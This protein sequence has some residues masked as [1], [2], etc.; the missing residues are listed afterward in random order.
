MNKMLTMIIA[1]LIPALSFGQ[2]IDGFNEVP[3]TGY[4][5]YEISASADSTLSFVNT[6]YVTD[7]LDEGSHALQLDYSAHNIESWGGYAKV[8][9]LHP[10]IATGGTYDWSGYDSISVRYYNS[11]AQSDEGTVHIRINLSDYAGITD[12]SYTGL[13][14]YYYS[15]HYVLDNEPGW[16]TITMPLVRNDSWDGGGF[17][18]TG[19]AGD[20]DD[21]EL[22]VHAIGGFHFEFSIGGSGEGNHTTGTIVLDNFKLTGYQGTN[23]VIF[24]GINTPPAWGNPFSWGGA[25]MYVT[26]GG[27]YDEGT[28]A[29][30]YIQEEVWSG[31]GFNMTPAVDFSSGGEW[32]SDSISFHMHSEESAPTLRLQF[33]DGTDKVGLNFDPEADGGWHHYQ[34]ALADFTYW[35]G[36]TTFDT[37]AVT[38]FQVMGEGNGASGRT[39]HFDNVWTGHPDFDVIAP[40]APE[41]IG[42]V[43]ANYYNLVTWSDVSG[44]SDELYHVYAS[45][46]PITDLGGAVELVASNVLEGSQA[47]V[48]YLYSPLEDAT[49]SYYYA[50]ICVDPAGN[51]SELGVSSSSIT[52][53][54]QGIPTISLDVPENFSADGDLSEWQDVMPFVI[55]P[56]TGHVATGNVDSDGD[57][58]GTVYLAVDDDYLYFA[59]DVVDDSYSY[60]E[61][62]WWNQD[63]LQ[64]FIGLYDWRGPK[65]TTINRGEEPDY[66]LYANEVGLHLDISNG[67]MLAAP[68]SDDYYF[69]GFDPDYAT[70]GRI[71]LDSIAAAN[72]DTRFHPV[73]GMRIPLDIYFHDNDNG[74]WEGNIGF[75]HLATDQQWNNPSEWAYTWI[76]DQSTVAGID[77]NDL[78][79]DDFILYPNYPN[80]FNPVTNI[81]FSL[82]E[83]Q[84]VKMNIFNMKGQLVNTLVNEK[85]PAGVH[86]IHWNARNAASGVYLYQLQ[87][88]NRSITQKMVLM[89]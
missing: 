5:D 14:E 69:E 11:V 32:Q 27:G 87:V 88:G 60:G 75:S 82:P 1:L 41:N 76:G 53:T 19:W 49:V 80:P 23:L 38:V 29:L 72:N 35:D 13:G 45:E 30:T 85:R 31:G 48:H 89:K 34:F 42:A 74:T 84:F 59:A 25:Q 73:N 39:F 9:H 21:G 43:P 63:A 2:L 54:A 50:V 47:A 40:D 3:D 46:E 57:L 79:A 18:L 83:D 81:R 65:H 70:E 61:G 77:D 4:W 17:N 8:Y 20:S 26:E 67:G 51:E 7:P 56:T 86:T 68:G 52:N 24:N 22:D 64:F 62:D 71:S 12:D 33:E 28:N 6:S 58:T 15:F 55:N 37:S 44:E 36:S 10:D 66:I 78:V 16:N